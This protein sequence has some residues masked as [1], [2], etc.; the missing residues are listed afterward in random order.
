MYL[1][2]KNIVVHGEVEDASAFINGHSIMVV[3]L[4]S[5]SGMRAKILEGMALGKVVLTTTVGLEGIEATHE[6]EILIGDNPSELIEAVKWCSNQ[7]G[8]LEVMG[9]RASDFVQHN[10]DS[11][12]IAKKVMKAY[13]T[14]TVE[15]V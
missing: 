6:Q 9:R 12:Q 8:R 15:I 4:L 13:S 5:G 10:Y 3:P 11:L 7:N 14:T 2:K 1:K